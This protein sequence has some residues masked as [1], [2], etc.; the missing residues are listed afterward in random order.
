MLS[1]VVL[2]HVL[3]QPGLGF[4]TVTAAVCLNVTANTDRFQL[5]SVIVESLATGNCCRASLDVH[6]VFDYSSSQ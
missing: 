4:L 1:T 2:P 6:C 5:L 3:Q